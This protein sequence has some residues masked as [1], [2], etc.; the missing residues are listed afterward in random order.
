MATP[1]NNY[2]WQKCASQP[3]SY[4][5]S[6]IIHIALGL[7]PT[8]TLPPPLLHWSSQTSST[9]QDLPLAHISTCSCSQSH[10]PTPIHSHMSQKQFAA[11]TTSSTH[12]ATCPPVHLSS[13]ARRAT[14]FVT[15]RTSS[16]E[17]GAREGGEGEW[18]DGSRGK[19]EEQEGSRGEWGR[20][21]RLVVGDDE[22][23]NAE[24]R[25]NNQIDAESIR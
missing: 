20:S 9:T 25:R 16:G 2:Q 3:C 24:G 22:P 4:C 5:M 18:A 11:P 1:H 6:L 14:D 15:C 13:A 23:D 21:E 12:Y 19:P 17:S 10:V 7:P 8:L